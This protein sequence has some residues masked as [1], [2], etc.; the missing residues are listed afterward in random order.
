MVQS[1]ALRAKIRSRGSSVSQ[2]AQTL[3]MDRG[4][5]YRR[6]EEPEKFTLQELKNLAQGLGMSQGEVN[7]IF[8]GQ[9]G[10]EEAGCRH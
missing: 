8:F 4:T 5:L 6:L 10:G 3:G 1:H 2:L 9:S 7:E